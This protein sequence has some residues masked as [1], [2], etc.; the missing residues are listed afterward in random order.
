MVHRAH[1][2]DLI[3]AINIVCEIDNDSKK[4]SDTR[5]IRK[6]GTYLVFEAT[7]ASTRRFSND[8]S[9]SRRRCRVSTSTKQLAGFPRR[10]NRSPF[11]L[12]EYPS[13]FGRRSSLEATL[14]ENTLE[15]LL[16]QVFF[17]RCESMVAS[18]RDLSSVHKLHDDDALVSYFRRS[19]RR[20]EALKYHQS[21]RRPLR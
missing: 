17:L 8:A 4:N 6:Q 10:T 12:L 19:R 18:E 16:D 13:R 11:L 7:R 15:D 21:S 14:F 2:E 9:T 3:L 20:A 1:T 5:H